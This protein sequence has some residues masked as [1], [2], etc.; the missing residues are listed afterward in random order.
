MI[1]EPTEGL[2]PRIVEQL[3]GFLCEI[4]DRGVSVLLVEQRLSIALDVSERVYVMGHGR[5]VFEGTPQDLRAS[6]TVR[7]EWLE[8]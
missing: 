1:D 3:A 5:I 6:D 7:R 4:R 2:A 8:V